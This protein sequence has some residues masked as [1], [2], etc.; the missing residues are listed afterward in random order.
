MDWALMATVAAALAALL[1]VPPA[2]ERRLA[3]PRPRSR[4]PAWLLP[5]PG[6]LGP[7]RRGLAAA[8]VA[9][10]I[11]TW[12]GQL[13]WLAAPVALASGGL[14]FVGLGRLAPAAKAR[15][16]SQVVAGL[17]QAC[18]LL[19]AAVDSG[20]PL[21]LAVAAVGPAVGGAV[22][23]A[24]AGVAARVGLGMPESQAWSELA[25]EPGMEGLARELARTVPS[26]AGVA[27]LL[28]DLAGEA[29]RAAATEAMVRA[30]RVGVHSVLP[31]IACFLPS[32]LLLG[33]VPLLGGII[34]TALR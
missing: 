14:A 11:A 30:R 33:I 3:L 28:R 8:A 31:V 10:A 6:A 19:A 17:P 15:R 22:G 9:A 21:R 12:S 13:G 24:L 1:A 29:R 27:P 7:R 4:L 23:E 32:F 2:P 5:L 18:D 34:A 20:I 16:R 26:G 25:A